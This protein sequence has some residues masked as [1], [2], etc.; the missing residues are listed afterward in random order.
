[1]NRLD[2]ENLISLEFSPVILF[3]YYCKQGNLKIVKF[4]WN[5]LDDI[6]KYE[7]IRNMVFDN[8]ITIGKTIEFYEYLNEITK[9][10]N[11]VMIENSFY[12]ILEILSNQKIIKLFINRHFKMVESNDLRKMICLKDL[13]CNKK[14]SKKSQLQIIKWFIKKFNITSNINIY[15]KEMLIVSSFH[16]GNI[17]LVKFLQ[18]FFSID[19]SKFVF[20]RYINIYD[21]IILSCSIKFIK[22]IITKLKVRKCFL[23][24]IKKYFCCLIHTQNIEFIKLFLKTFCNNEP[25]FSYYTFEYFS[26]G[27][28]LDTTNLSFIIR[29]VNQLSKPQIKIMKDVMKTYFFNLHL[30]NIHR[31]YNIY[32]FEQIQILEYFHIPFDN[33]D[34]VAYKKFKIINEKFMDKLIIPFS[35]WEFNG[36]KNG[37]LTIIGQDAFYGSCEYLI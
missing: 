8:F 34:L 33:Q 36:G 26:V 27:N 13:Y 23:L 20:S 12:G 25:L 24:N 10:L 22:W 19:I 7:I 29:I 6:S 18:Y 11:G 37:L 3:I 35:G 14:I 21:H 31:N 16:S 1:M 30:Y 2:V 5:K 4:I 32:M 9:T 17:E 28:I 15:N